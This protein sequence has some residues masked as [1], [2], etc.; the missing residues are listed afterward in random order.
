[1]SLI[2]PGPFYRG[3]GLL[4]LIGGGMFTAGITSFF[5]DEYWLADAGFSQHFPARAPERSS[6]SRILSI[7]SAAAG[8][9][10]MIYAQAMSMANAP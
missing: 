4:C 8:A 6:V 5:G 2:V 9:A 1:M 10:F 3:Y 7:T